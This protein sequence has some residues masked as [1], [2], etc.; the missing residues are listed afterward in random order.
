M[1]AASFYTSFP[2]KP[3]RKVTKSQE[4]VA[5]S[6]DKMSLLGII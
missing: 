1:D 2:D 4:C 3:P 5:A 6:G